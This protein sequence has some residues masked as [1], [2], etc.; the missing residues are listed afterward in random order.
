MNETKNIAI[1]KIG[2]TIKFKNIKIAQG[3]GADIT[4]FSM[5]ARINPTY[6]FYFIGP[7]ELKKLSEKEYDRIFPN[8]NVFD[9]FE[10]DANSKEEF[11]P[12]VDYFTKNNI[13]IDFGMFFSGMCSQVNI[14]NFLNKPDGTPYSILNSYKSYCG[15]YLYFVNETMIPWYTLSEDARYVTI[16]AKDIYNRERMSFSEFNG[17]LKCGKR[18]KSKTDH[19]FTFD[20]KVKCIY[21]GIEKI[22]LNGINETWKEDIDLD[23]KL[24]NTGNHVIQLS[25]GCGTKKI[26]CAGN[27]SSRLDTYKK[28]VIDLFKGTPYESTKIYGKW[29]DEIYEQYP[30]IQDKLLVD[31]GD[32]IADAKYTLVYSQVP[33]FVTI[34]P[35]EMITLGIIPFL[36]PDYDKDHLL[37]FPEYVYLKTPQD[38]LNKINELENNPE[39]YK[40]VLNDCF[41]MIKPEHLNGTEVNNF[42]FTNIANDLGFA[43]EPSVTGCKPLFNRFSKDLINSDNI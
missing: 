3:A 33:G 28:W 23:R 31:L 26:D 42:I 14:P 4:F 43:Y 8:H 17:T 5:I 30:E 15:P 25:N 7:N 29:D 40:K 36:H 1:G 6:N 9:V 18:V 16:H 10:K 2:K 34:K 19:S 24:N 32:E 11:Y 22:F 37:N 27:N 38:F 39:L 35:W 20:D 21:S 12:I 41:N 13:K